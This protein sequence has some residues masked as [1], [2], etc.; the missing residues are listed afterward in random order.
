MMQGNQTADLSFVPFLCFVFLPCIHMGL[1]QH[2]SVLSSAEAKL[3]FSLC[4]QY[5]LS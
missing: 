4:A 3:C 5:W 1:S 2:E